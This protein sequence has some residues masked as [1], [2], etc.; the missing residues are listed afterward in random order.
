MPE[1]SN[2]EITTEPMLARVAGNSAGMIK[3]ALARIGAKR[4]PTQIFIDYYDGKHPFNFS[5]EKFTNSFGERLRKFRDN[6]C[7]TVVKAPADRLEVVG[8]SSDKESDIY[9]I[10]W[11][12]WKYSQ[13][14]KIAK[15]IHRD[16]FKTS[17]AYIVVWLDDEGR[18]R[19]WRQDPRTCCV[20]YN[21]ETGKIDSGAKVWRGV[22]NMVYLTLYFPDRIEKYI[23]RNRQAEGSMPTTAAAFVQR[24]IDGEAWPLPNPAPGTCSMFHF[25]LEKSI[26][27]DVIPLNDA[28]NKCVADLL[29]SSEANSIRQRWAS[30]VQFERDPESGNQIIPWADA[31]AWI[32]SQDVGAKFGQ[33]ENSTLK[34]F[35]DTINDFRAEVAS[36]S[37]IPHYYFRLD[38]GSMPSGEAL[39]KAESRF[40]SIIKDAQLDF[41]E[42]WSDAVKYALQLQGDD[43][44]A[45]DDKNKLETQWSP[46]DP[47]SSNELADLII[48]KKNIGISTERGLSELGY[49]EAD[50][51]AMQTQ[52]LETATRNAENFAGIF[53]AGKTIGQ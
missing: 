5:S 19:I 15:R 53:D 26:L 16:A 8:F 30:G 40:T 1:L 48:K 17:D 32:A 41:G 14:P 10:S 45:G 44:A 34:D 47:M 22:D 29:V 38:G 9:K 11:E 4:L 6:L 36:V 27:D 42:T 20:F 35:V 2:S 33:F 24:S 13:M 49:T 7:P 21:P 39:R 52:N 12:L 46:A 37:G 3:A 25:G 28:L 51:A 31:A 50:I 23:T 43:A 18:S